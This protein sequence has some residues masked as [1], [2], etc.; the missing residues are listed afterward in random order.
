MEIA[1]QP[2]VERVQGLTRA[3]LILVAAPG[4]ILAPL[5][6]ALLRCFQWSFPVALAGGL[7]G[8]AAVAALAAART[9]P[10]LRALSARPWVQALFAALVLLAIGHSVRLAAFVVDPHA[11][12]HSVRPAS[13]F[14]AHHSCPTAYYRAAQV[15]RDQRPPNVYE[16]SFYGRAG[17]VPGLDTGGLHVDPYEYTPAFL[18]VP[19]LLLTVSHDYLQFR[20]LWTLLIAALMLLGLAVVL[21]YLPPEQGRRVALASPWVLACLPTAMGLQMG[22]VHMALVAVT[23]VAMIAFEQGRPALGGALLGYAIL[24]KLSP[25]IL[26]VY[27][28]AR[29]QWKALAWTAGLGAALLGASLLLFGADP[30]RAFLSYQLPRL[31]S[32]DAFPQLGLTGP[33][34]GNQSLPGLAFKLKALGLVTA[35]APV[36]RG[37]GWVLTALLVAAAVIT[38]RQRLAEPLQ[39][40]AVCL[41]LVSAAAL[42]SVFVPPSYGLYP[43]MWLAALLLCVVDRG[44]RY[45]LAACALFV[46]LPLLSLPPQQGAPP[47]LI[48]SLCTAVQVQ[49]IAVIALGFATARNATSGTLGGRLGSRSP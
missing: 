37:V 29:R 23:V 1:A 38:G 22:N 9:P 12:E 30:W 42:R 35:T 17:V 45:H 48:A 7:L 46:C 27:L 11:R 43:V 15:L 6:W 49:S 10:H 3:G 26:V 24:G 31:D 19:R 5:V 34:L 28:L 47:W 13:D 20:A 2:R 8:G 25:G 18:L 14:L 36:A 16:P 41:A 4:A 21:V 32:G 39:R 40:L 33:M 44:K